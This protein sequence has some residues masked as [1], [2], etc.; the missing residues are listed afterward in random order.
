LSWFSPWLRIGLPTAGEIGEQVRQPGT[1]RRRGAQGFAA[2]IAA[3]KLVARR[4]LRLCDTPQIA[5]GRTLGGNRKS[6]QLIV[7]IELIE[8]Y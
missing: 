8:K 4:F 2:Q 5:D 7:A 1:D 6:I 3:G